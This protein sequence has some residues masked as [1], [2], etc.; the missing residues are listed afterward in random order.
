[1]KKQTSETGQ[2]EFEVEGKKPAKRGRKP[3]KLDEMDQVDGNLRDEEGKPLPSSLDF[4]LGKSP[5]NPFGTSSKEDYV[6]KL[7]LMNLSDM[8]AHASKVGVKFHYDRGSLM[9]SLIEAFCKFNGMIEA[10][11]EKVNPKD[12]VTKLSKLAQQILKQGS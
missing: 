9:T 10:R 11:A 1:M 12:N 2:G 5:F 4:F 3:K 6:S 8:Q 7:R